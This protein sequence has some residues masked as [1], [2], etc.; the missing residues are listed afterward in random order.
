M[1]ET[2]TG[3]PLAAEGEQRLSTDWK[4]PPSLT[5]APEKGSTCYTARHIKTSI[6]TKFPNTQVSVDRND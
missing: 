6:W 1:H 2:G 3:R 4:A 5:C